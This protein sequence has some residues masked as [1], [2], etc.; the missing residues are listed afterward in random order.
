[1]TIGPVTAQTTPAVVVAR[2]VAREAA[3]VARGAFVAT[4]VETWATLRWR[5]P[6]PMARLKHKPNTSVMEVAKL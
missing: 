4:A 1:L 3:V 5:V 2:E 6:T